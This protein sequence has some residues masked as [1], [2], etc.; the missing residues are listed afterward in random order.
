MNRE[1][2]S[3]G[4]DSFLDVVANIVGILIILVMV[5]GMRMAS[6]SV[7]TA[8]P[9]QIQEATRKLEQSVE[10]ERALREE[11]LDLARRIQSTAAGAEEQQALRDALARHL[12]EWE[13]RIEEKRALL[14]VNSRETFDV[15]RELEEMKRL[16]ASLESE[17]AQLAATEKPPVVIR[18]HCTPLS[19]IVSGPE[20]HF[21]I[22]GGRVSYIP[23]EDLLRELKRDVEPKIQRLQWQQSFTETLGPIGGYRMKYTV[24]RVELPLDVQMA[25]GRGGFQVQLRNWTLLPVSEQLGEPLERALA[26]ASDFRAALA[27]YRPGH[28]TVTF[29]T[30]DD[31]YAQYRRLKE[32]LFDLG[33][34]TAGR[35]LP[36]GVP[37]QGSPDGSRSAAQ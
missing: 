31:S 35:P 20:A 27:K 8:I 12:A 5:A 22:S 16:L 13:R 18:S 10:T 4:Q 32:T 3:V 36:Q 9:A 1:P 17:A 19:Q 33:Y 26:E 23:L 7:E 37:I 21:R 30:Y 28:T 34:S 6:A 29:W 25:A 11:V 24:E 14:D 15:N 2:E